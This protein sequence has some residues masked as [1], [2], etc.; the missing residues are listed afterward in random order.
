VS[1]KRKSDVPQ[2]QDA[3][4]RIVAE[5]RSGKLMPGERMTETDLAARLGISRTPVREAIRQLEAD[6]LVTHTPRIGATIR[7]LDHAEI[8]ELYEMRT[9]LEGTT[10]RFAARA[11]SDVELAELA[12][13]NQAM[14][15]AEGAEALYPLNQQFHRALLDAARNRFLV[16]AVGA[17]HKSLLILG[18]STMI[19]D[20]R[21][22][23]A[24]EEPSR[25]LTALQNRDPDTAEAAMRAHIEAAHR[26][27]L[28]Q[29][30]RAVT[31][32]AE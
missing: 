31:E 11:A 23:A 28:R 26:A 17:I 10:A 25:V 4:Q 8:S 24:Q 14:A 16:K 27:R 20:D 13:I 19:E 30:R 22:S 15:E 3:Y 9:V 5:I 29:L 7:T 1:E 32:A 21:A 2:G 12:A 18:P 6:G